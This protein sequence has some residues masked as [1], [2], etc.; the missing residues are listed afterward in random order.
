MSSIEGGMN[1]SYS[2]CKRSLA[3]A[4]ARTVALYPSFDA[5]KAGERW[6]RLRRLTGL[7]VSPASVRAVRVIHAAASEQAIPSH[8]GTLAAE[9]QSALATHLAEPSEIDV[10]HRAIVVCYPGLGDIALEMNGP[11]DGRMGVFLR[12]VGEIQRT[13]RGGDT[14]SFAVGYFCNRILPGSFTHGGVLA[15]L[16]EFFPSALIWYGMLSATAPGFDVRLFGR[17]LMAKLGRDI[18]QPFSF[19]HRP[20]CDLSLDE[21]EVLMRAPVRADTIKPIHQKIASIA[22]L[23]GVDVFSRF[24]PDED[25]HGGSDSP[26]S[27]GIVI[28]QRIVLATRLMDEA[29]SLLRE[30]GSNNEPRALPPSNPKRQRKK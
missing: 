12:A 22:L 30:L 8:E 28:D 23:P 2:A 26:T 13:S 21:L 19:A 7:A 10:L 25:G 4:L 3:Y 11:F 27:K 17:G 18:A 1:P 29:V 9:L 6:E 16:V 5:G 20:R 14:D 24:S 15:R